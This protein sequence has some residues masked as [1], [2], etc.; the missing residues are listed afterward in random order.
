VELLT[1]QEVSE[2]VELKT[3]EL[4]VLLLLAW[5]ARRRRLFEQVS[6]AVFI[7]CV[8]ETETLEVAEEDMVDTRTLSRVMP[9]GD[10]AFVMSQRK[11]K[12]TAALTVVR[13]KPMATLE[14]ETLTGR[15][16]FL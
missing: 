7:G 9:R 6:V 4:V 10:K 11:D 16:T 1:V 2:R 8:V 5:R 3:E 14:A 12:V 13:A 15:V